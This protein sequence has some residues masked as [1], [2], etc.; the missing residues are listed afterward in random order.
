MSV[1]GIL[2]A[3]I[4]AW[5]S[6][7]VFAAGVAT[8]TRSMMTFGPIFSGTTRDMSVSNTGSR[9]LYGLPPLCSVP[10]WCGWWA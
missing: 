10:S 5:Q 9:P 4:G 3:S 8:A 2:G 1:T 6:S 7:Q